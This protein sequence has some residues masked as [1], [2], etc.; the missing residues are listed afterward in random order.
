MLR[1]SDRNIFHT[2][3]TEPFDTDW[4]DGKATD[5]D[6]NRN[7]RC[8]LDKLQ[9]AAASSSDRKIATGNFSVTQSTTFG[10]VQC[11]P[12]LTTQECKDCLD[13]AFGK[14]PEC[15]TN[16]IRGR[17]VMPSCNVRYETGLTPF[18]IKTSDHI[19]GTG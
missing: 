13:E 8:L 7:V 4:N 3:K 12:D 5:K 6:F 2:N 10:M 18:F 14:L 19:P 1:Y 15:C 17:V 9:A 16:K 11:T